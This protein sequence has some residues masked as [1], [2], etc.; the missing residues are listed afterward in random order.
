MLVRGLYLNFELN[1]CTKS[2]MSYDIFTTFGLQCVNL[3]K[4][5]QRDPQAPRRTFLLVKI[6]YLILE[7]HFEQLKF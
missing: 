5:N 2:K 3:I 6:A 4:S 7:K 1:L